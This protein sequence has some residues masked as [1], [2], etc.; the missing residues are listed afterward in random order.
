[1]E[2]ENRLIDANAFIEDIKTEIVELWLNGLKGTP[3][4]R[5]Q[6]Y[7]FINRIGEQP[8]VDAVEV[9]H[10]D[11]INII[12]LDETHFI[13]FCSH[14]GTEQVVK[15]PTALKAYH[16]YCRWCGAK[17]DGGNEDV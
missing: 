7:D 2:N 6:L 15:F 17:M 1:M 8:T 3:Q 16:K 13:G 4:P 14:C 11:W 12:Q 5:D 9:V 10:A